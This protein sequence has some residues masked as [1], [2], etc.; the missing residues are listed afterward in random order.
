[1]TPGNTP[2]VD[3]QRFPTKGLG[4]LQ[5]WKP[6]PAVCFQNEN[7]MQCDTSPANSIAIEPQV[8]W[9]QQKFLIA[10]TLLYLPENAQQTWLNQLGIWELGSDTDPAFANRI[11]LHLPNGKTYIAK[12]FGKETILGK[13]VQKGIA[14]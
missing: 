3:S 1:A 7:S 4:Y 6:N 11:E 10:W 5:W 14:A 12:T 8:G 13:S 2:L 9:E